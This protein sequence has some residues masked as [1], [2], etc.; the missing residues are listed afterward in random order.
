MA[1]VIR[2]QLAC[3][4]SATTLTTSSPSTN[5]SITVLPQGGDDAGDADDV[6][7]RQPA[8]ELVDHSAPPPDDIVIAR[9]EARLH[10]IQRS[11]LLGT[12]IGLFVVVIISDV[13]LSAGLPTRQWTQLK[14]E[15]DTVRTS[16]FAILLVIIGYFFGERRHR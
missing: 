2:C 14:P 1:P 7:D 13:G 6:T 15:I 8:Y 11:W 12:F 10:G 16:M 5:S 3:P 4:A 9:E